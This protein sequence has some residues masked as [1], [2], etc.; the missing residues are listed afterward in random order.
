MY[1]QHF[2]M[3]LNIFAMHHLSRHIHITVMIL[4]V[5]SWDKNA[6]YKTII[7]FNAIH[8]L[9]FGYEAIEIGSLS[10]ESSIHIYYHTL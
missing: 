4:N 5:I 2:H 8:L 9:L 10:L 6:Y 1:M 3:Y 7:V